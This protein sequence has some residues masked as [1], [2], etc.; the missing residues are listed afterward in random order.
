MYFLIT[1]KRLHV[2]EFFP[3]N[4]VGNVGMTFHRYKFYWL[5]DFNGTAKTKLAFLYCGEF[6]KTLLHWLDLHN[7]TNAFT[8]LNLWV[9][10]SGFFLL[11]SWL[12]LWRSVERL[13]C[14]IYDVLK[15]CPQNLF[16]KKMEIP[17]VRSLAGISPGR[18]Y[19][20]V[21]SVVLF[22]L[23]GFISTSTAQFQHILEH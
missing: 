17:A 21:H 16:T 12:K 10:E 9:F 20:V 23:H 19:P 5:V 6:V 7:D 1:E 11:D 8:V 2:F 4:K 3:Q 13:K 14:R 22:T 18:V 15:L